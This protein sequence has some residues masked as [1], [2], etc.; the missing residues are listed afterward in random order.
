MTLV[1]THYFGDMEPVVRQEP[2]RS[3]KDTNQSTKLSTQN[4]FCL[5]L[6]QAWG[7]EQRQRMV[8]K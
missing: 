1:E 7:R 6:M 8:D 4:L 2:E 3:D 5:Q